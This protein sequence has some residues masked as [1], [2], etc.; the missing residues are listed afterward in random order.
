MASKYILFKGHVAS[1]KHSSPNGVVRTVRFCCTRVLDTQLHPSLVGGDEEESPGDPYTRYCTLM[2][3]GYCFFSCSP[4][5]EYLIAVET[6]QF[7]KYEAMKDE[8]RETNPMRTF[9]VSIVDVHA[10]EDEKAL[11]TANLT[12]DQREDAVL[13]RPL[14]RISF[15]ILTRFYKDL[16]I[17]EQ[18]EAHKRN[19]KKKERLK[20]IERCAAIKSLASQLET[21][22]LR[23]EPAN[24][25]MC[26]NLIASMTRCKILG[27]WAAESFF[28]AI[29]RSY[30]ESTAC[31]LAGKQIVDR[32]CACETE[33]KLALYSL[34]SDAWL[35]P[36]LSRIPS[37]VAM[38]AKIPLDH[39]PSS[40]MIEVYGDT[41]CEYY[42]LSHSEHEESFRIE[43]AG[44][45][46]RW[47][48]YWHLAHRLQNFGALTQTFKTLGAELGREA[49]TSLM[50]S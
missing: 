15:S 13:E 12:E 30:L 2:L 40:P 38:L 8:Q 18:R 20:A 26:A 49:T 7:T 48:I 27:R 34:Y 9:F 45:R 44:W 24:S 41:L 10:E 3:Y 39:L 36:L 46:T 37:Y 22:K 43:V 50:T 31:A 29:S 42:R 14:Y 23:D 28:E 33:G 47:E 21:C 4:L 11:L 6:E 16:F 17:R 25:R 1:L 32:F 19:P 35:W 5:V